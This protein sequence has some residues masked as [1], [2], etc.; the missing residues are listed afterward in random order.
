MEATVSLCTSAYLPLTA[1]M[2]MVG[3]LV[4]SLVEA[5]LVARAWD[6]VRPFNA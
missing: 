2:G 1:S 5:H 3:T 4:A 6:G